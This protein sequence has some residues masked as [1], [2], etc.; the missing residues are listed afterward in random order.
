MPCSAYDTFINRLDHKN[1]QKLDFGRAASGA[2]QPA[3]EEDDDDEEFGSALHC[4]RRYTASTDAGDD[5]GNIHDLEDAPPFRGGDL[6]LAAARHGTSAPQPSARADDGRHNAAG[7]APSSTTTGAVASADKPEE[8]D[9]MGH[10][11]VTI[12]QGVYIYGTVGSGKSMMMDLFTQH[13][14][15]TGCLAHHYHP[16]DDDDDNEHYA[17]D[18]DAAADDDTNANTGPRN[19]S[20]SSTRARR[21]HPGVV[22]VHFQPFMDEVRW[23]SVFLSDA[24]VLLRCSNADCLTSCT[25]AVCAMR[26]DVKGSVR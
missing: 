13:L 10:D 8:L 26:R 11:G 20:S 12:P 17:S 23:L 16:D 3:E 24:C 21:S 19:T 6:R 18:D 4:E 15:Q 9:A 1:R 2:A 5:Y 22:R 7:A 14:V 25:T